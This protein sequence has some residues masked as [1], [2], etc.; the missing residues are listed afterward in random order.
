MLHYR[1]YFSGLQYQRV[2]QSPASRLEPGSAGKPGTP[3][4]LSTPASMPC[5]YSGKYELLIH[6]ND[7]FYIALQV[8]DPMCFC[9][10]EYCNEL[11]ESHVSSPMCEV[12]NSSVILMTISPLYERCE[13]Y[14]CTYARL[15]LNSFQLKCLFFQICSRWMINELLLSIHIQDY[16]RWWGPATEENFPSEAEEVAH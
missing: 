4:F 8:L 14:T 1:F 2:T 9:L 5:V 3:L 6:V 10:V 7:Y 12:N 16:H 13:E 11:A 15:L